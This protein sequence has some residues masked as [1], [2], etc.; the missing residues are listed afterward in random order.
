VIVSTVSQRNTHMLMTAEGGDGGGWCA[1]YIYNAAVVLLSY[2]SS[3][4]SAARGRF[5]LTLGV[6]SRRPAADRAVCVRRV[7]AALLNDAMERGL[8]ALEGGT[9]VLFLFKYK[10][11]KRQY[12]FWTLFLR[13]RRA[14]QGATHGIYTLAPSCLW[15][16]SRGS[17]RICSLTLL[18]RIKKISKNE[19]MR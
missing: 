6:A 17:P 12:S 15:S 9:S 13:E 11:E 14:R 3:K 16:G 18:G 1:G 5:G 19:S 7:C 4:H 10:T 8:E 2:K